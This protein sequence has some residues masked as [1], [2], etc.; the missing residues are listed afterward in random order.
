LPSAPAPRHN[1]LVTVRHDPEGAEIATLRS[2]GL[3]FAGC[4]VLEIGCG[5]GRLTRLYAAEASSVIA[6]DPDRE[7]IRSFDVGAIGSV[8]VR[9]VAFAEFAHPERSFDLVLLSWAL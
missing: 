6:I 7:A 5:D 3:S 4:R 1:S 9:A 8:D 2:C